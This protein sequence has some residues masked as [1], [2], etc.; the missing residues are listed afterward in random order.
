[1]LY[2]Y[3]DQN[4]IPY[5]KC[6]KLI[7]SVEQSEVQRLEALFDRATKNGCKGVQ[8]IE[9]SNIPDIEPFCRGL[10]AIFSPHTGIVDYS[11]VTKRFATDFKD[12]NGEI[13]LN[14]ELAAIEHSEK[15]DYP[16]KLIPRTAQNIAL[17]TKFLI[18]C[19]GLHSDSVA[20]LSGCSEEPKILPVRGEYLC[21]TPEKRHIVKGNIYPVPD[22]S[23]PFLG[24]HFTPTIDGE[25]LLGPNAM[26][27]CKKEGYARSDFAFQDFCD[28]LRFRG[29]RKLIAKNI[30][31]GMNELRYG[32]LISTQVK[33]LQKYIPSLRNS[34]V[35]RGRCG[36]RAQAI[37]SEGTLIEDF[38]FDYGKGEFESNVLHVRNAP[39]PGATSSLAIAKVISQKAIEKFR[40]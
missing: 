27:A 21:L 9:G 17:N 24:V 1:M 3:L 30:S 39:S 20:K 26:V 36:I 11:V 15:P 29:T 33:R 16:I 38:I 12:L 6:G 32:L 37:D 25:V 35:Q 10:K 23:Y 8:I 4:D 14:W 40:I 19:A 18:A 28:L 31:F 22:P 13:F 34:D 5:K 2:D 7:V